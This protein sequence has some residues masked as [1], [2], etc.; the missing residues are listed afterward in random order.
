MRNFIWSRNVGNKKI[1]IVSRKNCCKSLME[2]GLGIK[3]IKTFN[4]A[5]IMHLCWKF[6]KAK[7]SC[8]KILSLRVKTNNRVIKQ[9]IKFSTWNNIKDSFAMIAKH[10]HMLVGN[11]KSTKFWL[12]IW[13]DDPLV[14]KFKIS[15]IYHNTLTST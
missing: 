3:S 12:D 5:S 4:D 1:M 2:G 11:G 6:F 8:S 9:S 7:E 13:L 14:I 15:D 10:S